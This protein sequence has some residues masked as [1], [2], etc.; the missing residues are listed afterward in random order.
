VP[1]LQIGDVPAGI[2]NL[3]EFLLEPS[4]AGWIGGRMEGLNTYG[5]E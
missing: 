4:A 2:E 1:R 5:G 3:I